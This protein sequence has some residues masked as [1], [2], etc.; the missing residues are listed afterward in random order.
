MPGF[1][2]SIALL[3]TVASTW[4]SITSESQSVISTPLSLM[5]TPTKSLHSGMSPSAGLGAGVPAAVVAGGGGAV[6][7]EAPAA[8]LPPGARGRAPPPPAALPGGS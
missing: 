1:A 3:W 2:I 6:G 8:S 4:P 7:R 5:F